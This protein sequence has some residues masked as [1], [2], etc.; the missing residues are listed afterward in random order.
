MNKAITEGLALMPPKF[1]QGLNLWSRE[2]GLTGQGSY[3]GQSNAAFVP[4]D[5]DF[6]GCLELEKT[7]STQKLRCFQSIPF[8]PGLY[9]RV[10]AKVK[11]ISGAFP[12]VRIAGW[13]GSSS[14][15][16]V[17]SADQT[18]PSVTLTTYGE[19]VSVTAIIGSGNRTGVDMIWGTA[20]V[21]GHFGL[22]LTGSNGS[23]IRIDDIEIED[24]SS[25]FHSVMFDWVDVRDYGAIG[26]GVT[27]DKAAFDAAD[28]AANGKRVIVPPGSYFIGSNL[29]IDNL[30]QFEGTLVMATTTRLQLVSN[31]DLANYTAAMGN[32]LEGF[33]KALH[34]LFY[35]TDHVELNLNGRRIELTEPIDVAAL[36]G[37]TDFA[38]RRLLTN[39]QIAAL[40]TSAWN[41]TVVTSKA[42]YSTS[43]QTRLSNV[44]NVNAI[45][46]GSRVTGTGVGR[47]VYVRSKNVSAGTVELSQP[48][49]G[50]N[51]SN[52]N[53]TF[54]RHKYMLDFSGLTGL[55]KFEIHD[56]EL[57]GGVYASIIMLAQEG[58]RFVLQD[59][60]LN[61][62]KDKGITSIYRGCQDLAVL[63]C[64]FISPEM[65]LASQDRTSI[66]LNVNANDCKI[67]NNRS[68]RFGTTA[69]MSGT[70]H[71]FVG[72]HFFQGDDTTSGVRRAGIVLTEP[73]CKTFITG[74]YID[75]CT[76][77]MTNEH[78]SNPDLGSEYTFGGLTITGNT[79]TVQD[80]A[81]GFRWIVIKPFGVNHSLQGFSVVGNVFR[82]INSNIDR[83]EAV[84]TTYA[85]LSYTSFKNITFS[86]NSFNGVTQ[87]TSS[88]ILIQHVQSTAA[89]T[90][91]VDSSDYLPFGGR[92]RNVEAITFEG[93][94][95]NTS[96]ATQYIM[97]FTQNE[98]GSGGAFVNLR[99]GTE[100]SG[101][102][103]VTLR[104]DN[105][106]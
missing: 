45:L 50:G 10:T 88:P 56:V 1:S 93:A 55:S 37:V 49:W 76:I 61:R 52:R 11:I 48:L 74:N 31:Y 62:P 95:K 85:A 102:A 96:N 97:P 3:Q 22:D 30:V 77:E 38:Q 40:D 36:T 87:P 43:S 34:A 86:A 71:M 79:F 60:V 100:V 12:S 58:Q 65:S 29:T 7:S 6:G 54:T 5:Q 92:A 28:V 63:N 16:N 27:D 73:N 39:G 57:M 13:A 104:C 99:F 75:N 68:V 72:N 21:L 67:R 53:Y 23:V 26:D 44:A 14:T 35:F 24:V 46:V 2:D 17:S 98:Q 70:G 90:W 59:S 4:N 106:V 41:D 47:E 105:P 80:V 20:P 103:W 83:V 64:E 89:E 51:V 94:I 84:D 91:T 9:L 69:V 18:G 81:P 101:T 32:E 82:T 78:D 19:V 15:A 33:K 8:L 42:N 25:I 66:V